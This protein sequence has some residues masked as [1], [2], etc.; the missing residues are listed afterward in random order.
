M[1]QETADSKGRKKKA[2]G[3]EK[4]KLSLLQTLQEMLEMMMLRID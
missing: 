1:R 4:Q 2:V 3:T